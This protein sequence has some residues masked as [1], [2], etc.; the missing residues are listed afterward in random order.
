MMPARNEHD[1]D[2]GDT[3]GMQAKTAQ[4]IN[5]KPTATKV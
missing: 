2:T 1:E 4:K 3:R 5:Y